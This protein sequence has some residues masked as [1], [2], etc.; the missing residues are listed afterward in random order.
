MVNI[1]PKEYETGI[2]VKMMFDV[3]IAADL[4]NGCIAFALFTSENKK[5][6]Q[7]S[8][9][10]DAEYIK[11]HYK[12]YDVAVNKIVEHLGVVLI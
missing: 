8:I 6:L 12:D 1:Q 3:A 9:A 7:D 4:I 5:V 10:I 11:K 2:A